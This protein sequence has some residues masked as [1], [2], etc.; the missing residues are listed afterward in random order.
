ML[1]VDSTATTDYLSGSQQTLLNSLLGG[2][3]G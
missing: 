2:S 1:N 3:N